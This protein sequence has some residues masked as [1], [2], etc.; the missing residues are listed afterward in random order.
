[1][2]KYENDKWNIGYLDLWL[3]HFPIAQKYIDP[4][5]L[6][7]PTF[8]SDAEGKHAYPLERVPL[9]ETWSA[10]ETLVKTEENPNGIIRSLGVANF[11][12]QLLYDLLSYAKVPVASLQ[13]EHHPYLVQP[14]LVGF[15]Q[16]SGIAIT[17]YSSFGPLS[18]V[19]LDGHLFD[20][21][22]A[23]MPLFEHPVVVGIAKAHNR[24]PAQVLL[25]WATQRN[26]AVI[27]KSNSVE[28]LKQNLENT[29]FDLSPDEIHNISKLDCGLR[30]INPGLFGIHIHA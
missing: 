22:R 6:E 26:I 17:A 28:R 19:G 3:I 27:P 30:F 4:K 23:T 18:Y 25:R 14:E 10:L 13:I 24:T 20:G 5:E 7:V 12:A 1:M 9:S 8:W 15:A 2:T 29:D 16:A 21:A 11:H